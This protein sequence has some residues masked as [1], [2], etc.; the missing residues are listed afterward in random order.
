VN[1]GQSGRPWSALGLLAALIACLACGATRS[2]ERIFNGR[3]QQGRYI[4]AEAYA[5]YTVGAY[6]EAHGDF[7]GAELAY[8][9]AL[10]RDGQSPQILTRLGA[11]ACRQSLPRAL[12]HFDRASALEEYAPAWLERAR[13]LSSQRQL[14][15]ALQ[16]ALRSVELDP[17]SVQ[18]NLLV[19]RLYRESA[20]PARARAWLFAW[21]LLEPEVGELDAELLRESKLLADAELSALV[22]DALRRRAQRGDPAPDHVRAAR[23][24]DSPPAELVAAIRAGELDHAREL[25]AEARIPPLQLSLIATANAKPDLGLSQAEL[26]LDANPRDSAALVAGLVA[27]AQLADEEAF[28][29]LLHRAQ[30]DAV[31]PLELA[32]SLTLL[33]RVR[34]GDEAADSWHQAYLRAIAASGT[35]PRAVMPGL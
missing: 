5:A 23:A 28:R 33:L 21:L 10:L 11:L 1:Q 25:A 20:Q 24:G 14:A 34:L 13:C 16:A 18:G 12:R 26:L 22:R 19:V 30:G 17:R 8:Q 3:T 6:R 31:P 15:A 2:T 32:R 9:Q 27:A 29:R 7:A 35:V 4:D